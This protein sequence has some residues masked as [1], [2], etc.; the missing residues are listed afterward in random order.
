MAWEEGDMNKEELEQK[1]EGLRRLLANW[2]SYGSEP[3]DRMTIDLVKEMLLTELSAYPPL[4]V[5]PFA[6]G[7][8]LVEWER[9]KKHLSIAVY[10]D[11]MDYFLDDDGTIESGDVFAVSEIRSLLEE[12]YQ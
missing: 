3:V 4:F 7:G 8:L 10:R 6:D 2:D 9:A 5:S 1:L 11:E 12:L